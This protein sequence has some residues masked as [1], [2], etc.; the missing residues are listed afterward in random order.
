M[1]WVDS[2]VIVSMIRIVRKWHMQI[3]SG[4]DRRTFG[5]KMLVRLDVSCANP[6]C[7]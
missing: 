4:Q 1:D 6:I 7:L 3:D 2:N 5:P